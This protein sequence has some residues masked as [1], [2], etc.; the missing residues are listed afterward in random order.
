MDFEED[1]V[2]RFDVGGKGVFSSFRKK[3]L[4]FGLADN[5]KR[6]EES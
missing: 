1:Y 4:F 6:R 3:N 5:E 2:I